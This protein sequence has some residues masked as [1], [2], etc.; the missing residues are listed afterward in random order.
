MELATAAEKGRG[1]LAGPHR[2]LWWLGQ[3]RGEAG[4]EDEETVTVVLGVG[5]LGTQRRAKEGSN[6]CGAERKRRGCIL[7]GRGGSGEE[8]RWPAVVEFYSSSVLKELKG[9]EETG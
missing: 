7:Q 3:W 5:Q 4:G 6:E 8:G 9:E 1:D 2:R